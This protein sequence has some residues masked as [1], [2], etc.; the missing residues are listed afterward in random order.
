[1]HA[2]V[3]AELLAARRRERDGDAELER[4]ARERVPDARRKRDAERL[5][6]GLRRGLAPV[7]DTLAGAR[8]RHLE[9]R[10]DLADGDG[11]A[12]VRALLLARDL[13]LERLRLVLR[14][15]GRRRRGRRPRLG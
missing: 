10:V 8:N 9:A 7:P 11:A 3:A 1:M 6:A 13:E 15:G 12:H 2:Q 5:R 14:L 4:L